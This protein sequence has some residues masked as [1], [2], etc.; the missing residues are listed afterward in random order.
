VSAARRVA[1][2]AV[3][4]VAGLGGCKG[5]AEARDLPVEPPPPAPPAEVARSVKLVPVAEGLT[6][7]VWMT[8]A[9]DDA[10]GRLFVVEKGGTVRL[11]RRRPDGMLTV[12]AA[13]LVDIGP[14][15]SSGQEQGLLG[16]AFHPRF[17]GKK[18]LYI[19]YTDKHDNIHVA[20]F[21]LAT[22]GKSVDYKS[23]RDVLYIKHPFNNH[24]GGQLI[25]GPDNKLYIGTGDGGWANDPFGNGQDRKSRLGKM[26]RLDVDADKPEPETIMVACAIRGA[27]T[28]IARRETCTSPTSDKIATRRST[29]WRTIRSAGRT[30]AGRSWRGCT[31]ASAT[32]AIGAASACPSS[33]TT[34]RRAAR[35]PAA[36]SIAGARCRSSTAS[37]SMPTIARR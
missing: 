7:P 6:Q 35:S 27:T 36:S 13:P 5:K 11:L 12:D 28:S 24:N 8:Y 26:L 17:S 14:R 32:A 33:S 23:E 34:T 2:V 37:I 30:S 31:A 19:H 20:E 22:D 15:L 3:A 4:V 18:K 29:S 9:R 21:R 25:F 1:L 10:E 16:L